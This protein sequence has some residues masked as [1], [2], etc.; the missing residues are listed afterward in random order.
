MD[1]LPRDL[2]R[3]AHVIAAAAWVGGSV[4]YLLVI[5]PGL[6]LAKAPPAVGAAMGALFRRLVT[7]S[8]GVLTL[9]GVYLIF[10]RL[11]LI[12]VSAAYLIVLALKVL[13]A[14]AMFA[15]AAVQAQE[16]RRVLKRR[17]S[18]WRVIPRV[19]LALGLLTVFL[20]AALTSLFEA[21]LRAGR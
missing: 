9:T 16:A 18:A 20:G 1:Q 14:L 3:A 8:V 17:G 12:T 5:G 11:T 2:F 10:D 4:M 15:L 6:R 7:L 13:A 21:G 19:I